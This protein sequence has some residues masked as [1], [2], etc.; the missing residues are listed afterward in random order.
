MECREYIGVTALTLIPQQVEVISQDPEISKA[1]FA[2]VECIFWEEGDTSLAAGN[3]I[4]AAMKLFTTY[5]PSEMGMWPTIHL[6][7]AWTREH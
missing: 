3:V 4:V 6:S 1:H 7:G 5:G 2:K